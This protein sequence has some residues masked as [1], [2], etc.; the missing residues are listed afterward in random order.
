MPRRT[1][2]KDLQNVEDAPD[3]ERIVADKRASKRSGAAKGRRRNRRYSKRLLD[4]QLAELE[5]VDWDS[6]NN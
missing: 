2:V 4:A 1:S 6:E 5:Y 3:L